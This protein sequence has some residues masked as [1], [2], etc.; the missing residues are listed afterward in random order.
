MTTS[1]ETARAEKAKQEFE[2][3]S[4]ELK[5]SRE[6]LEKIDAATPHAEV[7]SRLK[8][9]ATKLA[10]AYRLA[11]ATPGHEDNTL[12]HRF[13]L[14]I[15][16][17]LLGKVS[18]EI[19]NYFV[20]YLVYLR[21]KDF[22][23][24][25]SL[26]ENLLNEVK[27]G[28]ATAA[29]TSGWPELSSDFASVSTD[30]DNISAERAAQLR[31][32][33]RYEKAKLE[34]PKFAELVGAVGAFVQWDTL[35]KEDATAL[36]PIETLNKYPNLRRQVTQAALVV[37]EQHSLDQNQ[38]TALTNAL[39]ELDRDSIVYKSKP[40]V[41][42]QVR[43]LK[44]LIT[45]ILHESRVNSVDRNPS[46]TEN[47]MPDM[48]G[49]NT[50]VYDEVLS[51]VDGIGL[52]QFNQIEEMGL[53]IAL[54]EDSQK[55]LTEQQLRF[56]KGF[57]DRVNQL[58]LR[59]ISLRT[60]ADE[61]VQPQ[62]PTKNQ[63]VDVIR[64]LN[65]YVDRLDEL[66]KKAERTLAT[67]PAMERIGPPKRDDPPEVWEKF[68]LQEGRDPNGLEKLEG[69][70][71]DFFRLSFY[72]GAE[73]KESWHNQKEVDRFTVWMEACQAIA[74]DLRRE[75]D[76]RWK[77]FDL[78]W[79]T[80][81]NRRRITDAAITYAQSRS[82][83]ADYENPEMLKQ[84]SASAQSVRQF[85]PDNIDFFIEQETSEEL[86]R[87]PYEGEINWVVDE[88]KRQRL[89]IGGDFWRKNWTEGDGPNSGR[90]KMKAHLRKRLYERHKAGEILKDI[91]D[92]SEKVEKKEPL[93]E[94][95]KRELKRLEVAISDIVEIGY[96]I[97]AF[98]GLGLDTYAETYFWGDSP[99]GAFTKHKGYIDD[100]FP[101]AGFTYA[102][103]E[104]PRFLPEMEIIYPF[105]QDLIQKAR[106]YLVRPTDSDPRK[107][108]I[109]PA[110]QKPVDYE[111][112]IQS[113]KESVYGTR[114]ELEEY[115]PLRTEGKNPFGY[116]VETYDD[117]M[118]RWQYPSLY[119]FMFEP[120]FVQIRKKFD[121]TFEQWVAGIESFKK[122][123]KAA[124]VD[125][126]V[127]DKSPKEAREHLMR[128]LNTL[129]GEISGLKS[130]EMLDWNYVACLVIA[131]VDRMFRAYAQ[132]KPNDVDQFEFYSQ[133]TQ[134]FGNEPIT[135]KVAVW[136]HNLMAHEDEQIRILGNNK[137][138]TAGN[139]RGGIDMWRTLPPEKRKGIPRPPMRRWE[140]SKWVPNTIDL[141]HPN[142]RIKKFATA[143][144]DLITE[145]SKDANDRRRS[146]FHVVPNLKL[147]SFKRKNPQFERTVKIY[148]AT[149]EE[150]KKSAN[151]VA[152]EKK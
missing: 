89:V 106:Q 146:R 35:S 21:A 124:S 59:Y 46:L 52:T 16:G 88:I 85:T 40:K 107:I 3:A 139:Y 25:S 101:I 44:I 47:L 39:Q 82:L 29:A 65:K 121:Y 122:F 142:G 23:V 134:V 27:Q 15:Q 114:L 117:G 55:A 12:V 66:I 92:L 42:L 4:Q 11:E 102:A 10:R 120:E 131:F 73:P 97:A 115:A 112:R 80:F 9:A 68:Y 130:N 100:L 2:T 63:I 71:R 147:E 135:A 14:E 111:E 126:S 26:Q 61:I 56:L 31:V 118:F 137:L 72:Q 90:T 93:T 20:G 108:E 28:M 7:V 138:N 78:L 62:S 119:R 144:L 94:E 129:M 140:G 69:F 151:E 54:A 145:D 43:N 84:L 34:G 83:T 64:E 30:I 127:K 77:K 98:V 76:P 128:Q 13:E 60:S 109:D 53:S 67:T 18:R 133:I 125:L 36:T 70:A 33:P 96:T 148:G 49:V 79:M 57:R 104:S 116:V 37:D 32:S 99:A 143:I 19:F 51:L 8:D 103:Y 24:T 17:I 87:S 123:R 149:V 86:L 22:N 41:A 152:S 48:R 91:P 45:R 75:G 105:D 81:D 58:K 95:D 38:Q 141:Q 50:E 150:Q 113:I 74:K 1:V 6:L 110:T 5:V 136:L 132:T